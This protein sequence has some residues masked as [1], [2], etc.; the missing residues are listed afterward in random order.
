[1]K[2]YS[3]LGSVPKTDT[4]G[5]EGWEEVPLPPTPGEGEEL[6]WWSPPG[7]VIRPVKPA[8]REGYVWDW[9]QSQGLW[10]ESPLAAP[11]AIVLPDTGATS[12]DTVVSVT[13]GPTIL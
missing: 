11:D 9:S 8:Q 5:T 10:V 3:K 1:M 12:S 2:L 7:W 6:I 13:A 4:D